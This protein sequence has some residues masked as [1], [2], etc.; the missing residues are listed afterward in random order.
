[1]CD[2]AIY[3]RYKDE[4]KDDSLYLRGS[5]NQEIVFNT[6]RYNPTNFIKPNSYEV[7]LNETIKLHGRNREL[8]TNLLG[9]KHS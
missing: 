6:K 3:G 4:L 9:I 8:L 1:M 7:N 5:L 2:V